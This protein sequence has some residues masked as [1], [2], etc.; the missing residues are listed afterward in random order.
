MRIFP[1]WS[2]LSE[3]WSD[4]FDNYW[5]G[6]YAI[7]VCFVVVL[8]ASVVVFRFRPAEVRKLAWRIF[9][10]SA[11]LYGAVFVQWAY[12][13]KKWDSWVDLSIGIGTLA[14]V[15]VVV[16][17]VNYWC[18]SIL[19]TWRYRNENRH[20][21]HVWTAWL[22][23]TG[24]ILWL[25]FIMRKQG[26]F[27][28]GGHFLWIPPIAAFVGVILGE[29]GFCLKTDRH[30][31]RIALLGSAL[32][33]MSVIAG[34]ETFYPP[35]PEP[36]VHQDRTNA[37]VRAGAMKSPFALKYIAACK[38]PSD[39][40]LWIDIARGGAR[41]EPPRTIDDFQAQYSGECEFYVVDQRDTV[42]DPVVTVGG[43]DML[44]IR[45]I[46]ATRFCYWI[47]ALA[48]ERDPPVLQR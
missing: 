42:E 47:P 6:V 24:W 19:L 11:A 46:F 15:L 17:V 28:D 8:A 31:R 23:T 16:F 27:V 14:W 44:C 9:L 12:P 35:E 36:Y 10:A 13:L 32:L 37:I 21:W 38:N 5:H 3:F 43:V 22:C 29:S 40:L 45:N 20:N 18:L 41:S 26:P 30:P 1:W 25:I 34:I 2:D 33:S 7:G 48:I 4:L 39:T